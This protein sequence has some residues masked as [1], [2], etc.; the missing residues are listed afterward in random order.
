MNPARTEPDFH[1]IPLLSFISLVV[2]THMFTSAPLSTLATQLELA[3]IRQ[4]TL[5]E[6]GAK[7]SKSKEKRHLRGAK[8]I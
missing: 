1:D 6:G 5:C 8:F 3:R 4:P 2:A 7:A